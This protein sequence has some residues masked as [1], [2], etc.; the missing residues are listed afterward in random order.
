MAVDDAA[1]TVDPHPPRLRAEG[2]R[3]VDP[4]GREVI[5]RGVTLADPYFLA[6][7]RL[8]NHL[9]E[10]DF[11]VLSREWK[12]GIVRIPIHPGLWT[13]TEGY[14][15]KYV[16]PVVEWAGKYGMVALLDWH[17]HGNPVTGETEHAPREN[18]Y[19]WHGSPYTPDLDLA[20]SALSA[21]GGRYGEKSWVIYECFNEPTFIGWGEWRPVAEELVDTLQAA[22]PEAL[23]LVSGTD[24]G[25]DLGGALSDPV[26]RDNIVYSTHA[27]P[28]KGEAWKDVA[29]RLKQRSPVIIGEWGFMEHSC[30]ANLNASARDYAYPL[31]ETAGELGL[32]W[33]AWVWHPYWEPP[34][35]VSW[36]GCLPTEFGRIVMGALRQ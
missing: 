13:G 33:I 1:V 17:A 22:A 29:R 2:N 18:Q 9:C 35:L 27:Y 24:W 16:D 34:L 5:L 23:V 21:I 12:A 10:A 31:L 32:G 7:E 20:R 28:G 15:E 8:T 14:M 26:R 6:D 11:Y 25:Y 36:D 19:P 4:A 30:N 3:I